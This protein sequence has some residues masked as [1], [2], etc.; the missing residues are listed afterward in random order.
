M[1]FLYSLL[2]KLLY[3][4]SL[5]AL[6]LLGSALLRKREAPRRTCF[7]LA[8]TLL[9]LCG[10]GWV[11][12][13]L[14]KHLE[15]KYLPPNP[16]PQADCILILS[17]GTLTRTPPRPTVEVTDAGDR[18]LYGAY[19]YRQGK[20]T[21]IICTGGLASVANGQRAYADDMAELLE[22]LGISK[23]AIIRETQAGNTREHAL[24]L[25]TVLQDHNFKRVLL[26]TSAAHMPRSMG[27]FKRLCPFVEVIAA[28]TDFHVT[29][30]AA[31]PWY[32]HLMAIVPTPQHLSEFSDVMHEYLGMAYYRLR[33]WM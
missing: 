25:G 28:P 6:L 26:V 7:W 31:I 1:S 14:T 3:P 23:G 10:N 4:T 21:N 18:I 19:L 9:L 5:V 13:A 15:W 12:G 29:E 20:A 16:V 22:N 27:V 2:L 24:C 11:V 32:Q 30:P 33:G 17:G 8:V